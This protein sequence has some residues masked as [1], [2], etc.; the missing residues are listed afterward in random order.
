MGHIPIGESREIH[1]LTFEEARKKSGKSISYDTNKWIYYPDF[2]SEYRYF[3][4]TAGDKP[5]ITIGINPSTAEPN[6]LDNTIKTVER[7]ALRNGFDS[8]IMFNVYAQRATNPDRMDIS[9][10]EKLH[11]ENMKAFRWMLEQIDG[12]PHIWAA[13]GT[14]IEKRGYLKKCL[15][16]MVEIGNE[17]D[18]KW[19]RAGKLSKAGHPHHPLYL[20]KD[21]I[22]EVFE[23]NKYIGDK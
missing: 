23:I 1:I 9:L 17:Y 18:A 19:I 13:W 6:H 15:E 8:F 4:G 3:L 20:P 16:D 7:I 14:I 12:Q 11:I 5:L 10:N 21:S 22:F 2:Y